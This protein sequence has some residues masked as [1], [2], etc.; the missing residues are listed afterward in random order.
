[1]S[2]EPAVPAPSPDGFLLDPPLEDG[3]GAHLIRCW[4]DVTNA[5]GAVGLAAPVDVD[6]VLPLAVRTFAR[7]HPEGPD[8]LLVLPDGQGG[9]AA[10]CVLEAKGTPLSRHWMTVKRVQVRPDLQGRGLGRA[11]LQAVARTG[12]ELGLDALHLT[13]RSGTGTDAFYRGLGWAEVARIP[14]AIRVAPG[15]DRD[16]IYMVLDLTSS[17]GAG[18]QGHRPEGV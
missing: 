1:M 14:A 6:D 7:L 17:D 18:A 13:V 4:T 5:G 12:R 11:L 9:V 2:A 16:E 3:L 8:H 10:W 15:D